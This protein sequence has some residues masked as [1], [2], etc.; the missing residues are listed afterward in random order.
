MYG[1]EFRFAIPT[2]V[3]LRDGID[4][5][6]Y[7]GM[8][9]V[10]NEG[11]ITAQRRDRRFDLPEVYIQWDPTHWS[12]NK[13]PDQWTFQEHFDPVEE[14]P[15]SEDAD[16]INETIQAMAAEFAAGVAKAISGGQSPAA[17]VPPATTDPLDVVVDPEKLYAEAMQE[18]FEVLPGAEGFVLIVVNR[19]SHPE[20]PEGALMASRFGSAKTPEAEI[21]IGAQVAHTG[22]VFH[23]QTALDLISRVVGDRNQDADGRSA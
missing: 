20:A 23:R 3:K 8:A 6:F 5:A 1:K 19:E 13:Q 18:A 9:K 22:S 21:L 14:T 17:P 7:D 15:V 16:K 12:Y 2:R 10:G 11:W 4:P